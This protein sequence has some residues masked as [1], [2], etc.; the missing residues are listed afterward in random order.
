MAARILIVDDDPVV[1][2]ALADM[3]SLR[4]KDAIVETAG[5][6]STALERVQ[7]TDYDV[8]VSDIKMPGMDGLTL[9]KHI[10]AIRPA[11]PVLLMTGH[12]D[13][14]FGVKA[15][16]AG[17]YTFMQK[18]VDRD[19]LIAWLARAIH[20][21]RLSRE[22][23]D[24]NR[25]LER[26]AEELD[27][28]VKE[29]TAQLQANEERLR[30]ALAIARMV[31]WEWNP[32]TD[33]SVQSGALTD[34]LG[35]PPE[36]QI[37]T[38][39]DG[40]ALI[41]PDDAARVRRTWTDSIAR[42]DTC[43]SQFRVIRPDDGRTIWLEDHGRVVKDGDGNT[44]QV[45]G[46]VQDITERK[47][48]E[49]ELRASEERFHAIFNQAS[50]G[51]AQM[52][53]TG[54]FVLVNQRYCDI[55]GR[56]IPDVLATR[57]QDVTHPDD[58]SRSRALFERMVAGGPGFTLDKRYCLPNGSFVWVQVSTAL[59]TDQEGRPQYG[60]AVAQDIT[61]RKQAEESRRI[62]SER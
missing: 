61:E 5:A 27:A 16:A 43:V 24:K 33:R 14:E 44:V 23:E 29:R 42:G 31:A 1:L 20:E 40:F 60:I 47:K 58:L 22:V 26:H 25:Q 18:P 41:H 39:A 32:A 56:S 52:D 3:L 37:L 49:E 38:M 21:R 10:K 45:R 59:M 51:I 55:L 8:I 9:M 46:V 62:G 12:G 11:L 53:L 30:Q 4:M 13:H 7:D 28:I 48:A 2:E 34:V 57:V 15:L 17:A 36:R 54:R 6:G 19:F 50:V 35:L